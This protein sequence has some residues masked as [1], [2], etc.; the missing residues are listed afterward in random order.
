MPKTP[1]AIHLCI[2]HLRAEGSLRSVIVAYPFVHFL[3]PDDA[4]RNGLVMTTFRGGLTFLI[5]F[6]ANAPDLYDDDRDDVK[7]LLTDITAL[8]CELGGISYF[9]YLTEN[10]PKEAL[11]TLVKLM[12][13]TELLKVQLLLLKLQKLM[14][15]KHEGLQQQEELMTAF[16]K[17]L[18]YSIH[19]GLSFLPTFILTFELPR[20]NVQN[21]KTVWKDAET[22]AWE[23]SSVYHS[24]CSNSMTK[25]V[26]TSEMVKLLDR[27]KLFK[28]EVFLVQLLDS[29][30]VLIANVK[31]QIQDLFEGLI[32]IRT[33]IMSPLDEIGKLILIRAEKV[34]RDAGF[35]CYSLHSSEITEDVLGQM[36]HLL[37]ELMENVKLVKD[38]IM[39]SYLKI[40]RSLQSNFPKYCGLGFVHFFLGNLRELLNK[41]VDAIAS[42][43]HLIEVAYNEIEEIVKSIHMDIPEQFDDQC[44]LRN[45]RSRI[46]NVAYE[47]EYLID[48]FLTKVGILWYHVL[49]L[50]DLIEELKLIRIQV[51]E[52]SEKAHET[53][54]NNVEH[55]MI[56]YM[57]SPA[58]FPNIDEVV[59]D[60]DDQ[61]KLM[62]D[63]LTRGTSQQDVVS[64]VGMPGL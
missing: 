47:A 17:N 27:I 59:V 58:G 6:L 32:F 15:L 26:A 30:T 1:Q 45:L 62:I 43:K 14:D 5:I 7:M 64:I 31:D 56:N 57:V 41:K 38:E 34:A 12:E 19:E 55:S 16:V 36:I 54:A 40:R 42:V 63:R 51:S 50:F 44:D 3:I 23:A 2:L 10:I 11:Q 53:F 22:L 48:S 9:F 46:V 37:P 4:D 8:A 21:N 24:F 39:Q 20:V 35:L 60:L 33:F 28:V 13:N 25:Q 52:L 49:W 18:N 29:R 61:A